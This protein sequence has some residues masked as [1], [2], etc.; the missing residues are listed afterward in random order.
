ML[1]KPVARDGES[2]LAM[3]LTSPHLTPMTCQTN[4]TDPTDLG[5]LRPKLNTSEVPAFAEI[6]IPISF[7]AA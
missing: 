1:H 2:G 4:P 7:H 6:P 5:H 3:S